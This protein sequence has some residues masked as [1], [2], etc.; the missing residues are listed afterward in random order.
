MKPWL[1]ALWLIF[2][3]VFLAGL[4]VALSTLFLMMK[5][6]RI[7]LYKPVDNSVV[8]L[9]KDSAEGRGYWLAAI[10][11]LTAWSRKWPGPAQQ[12]DKGQAKKFSNPSQSLVDSG[13]QLFQLPPECVDGLVDKVRVPGCTPLGSRHCAS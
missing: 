3:Q 11:G 7:H 9:W 2:D 8:K 1:V 5:A 4:K 10:S 12:V 13:L 6:P